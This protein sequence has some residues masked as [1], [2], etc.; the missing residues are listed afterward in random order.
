MN[1]TIVL[2]NVEISASGGFAYDD[3]RYKLVNKR[4]GSLVEERGYFV[5]FFAKRLIAIGSS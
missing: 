3:G 2:L 5:T 4:P 1:E